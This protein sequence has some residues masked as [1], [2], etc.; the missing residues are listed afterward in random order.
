MII[1]AIKRQVSDQESYWKFQP[2]SAEHFGWTGTCVLDYHPGL[3]DNCIFGSFLPVLRCSKTILDC[4]PQKPL[5]HF[6]VKDLMIFD[7]FVIDYDTKIM[8]YHNTQLIRSIRTTFVINILIWLTLHSFAYPIYKL[9]SHLSVRYPARYAQHT[10]V[11]HFTFNFQLSLNSS[12]TC[13]H[14]S[15]ACLHVITARQLII[16]VVIRPRPSP[17][18]VF[19]SNRLSN[20]LWDSYGYQLESKWLL[21]Y[22]VCGRR[23]FPHFQGEKKRDKRRHYISNRRMNLQLVL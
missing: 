2:D 18:S 22:F 6:H 9:K 20:F 23:I 5:L 11:L 4:V 3:R 15:R 21:Q 17:R 13:T 7:D 10:Y 14:L 19:D 16:E 8:I 1:I 12:F